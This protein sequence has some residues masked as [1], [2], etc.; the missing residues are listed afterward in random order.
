MDLNIQAIADAKIQEMHDSGKITSAIESGIE[1]LVLKAVDDALGGYQLKRDIEDQIS[2]SISDVVK[3]IG[4]S[5]YNGF[6][7]QKVKEITEGVMREDVAQKIQKTFDDMLIARHDGIK[8]SEII[9]AYR[10]YLFEDVDES[11]KWERR[12]FTCGVEEKR[13][14]N[15]THIYVTLSDEPDKRNYD[16]DITITFCSYGDAKEEYISSVYFSGKKLGENLRLGTLTEVES[17]VA[18]L[19]YNKTPIILD[20]DDVDDSNYY[21]IDV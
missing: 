14:G 6:I 17:L 10:K 12:T 3:D 7:A 8:L 4:L 2:S 15:F 9:N 19:Y 20:L 21:D 18:N 11:D 16:S 5:A 1:S 13:D